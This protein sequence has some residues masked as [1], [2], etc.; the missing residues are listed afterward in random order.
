M[1]LRRIALLAVCMALT[2]PLF[3]TTIPPLL[4]Y[5]N[6]LARMA[7]L[8]AGGR[9]AD[10][11]QLYTIDWHIAPNLGLDM[12]VPLLAQLMP[13]PLA[14][15]IY[16]AL[17]L[18]LPVL[19]TV[20]LHDTVFG[21]RSWWPLASAIVVY[22]ATLL[23]G[24]LNFAIGIGLALLG[25]ACWIRLRHDRQRQILI[26]AA[27]AGAL[28]FIHAFAACFFLI[29][30]AGFECRAWQLKRNDRAAS[31][32]VTKLALT[33]LPTALLYL[34]T[35]LV[36]DTAASPR[37]LIAS[38]WSIAAPFDT[39]HKAIGAGASF[40]TYDTAS[41]LLLLIAVTAA[42]AALSLARKLAFAWPAAIAL[43]LMVVY[44]FVPN[45]IVGAGWVDTHLP[46]LAGFLL[47]AGITPRRLGRRET[48]VLGLA[49]ATLIVAR[50]G[51]ITLAWQ[52]QNADLANIAAVLTPVKADD[53]VLVLVASET[54]SGP[55][56]EPV[57]WRFFVDQPSFWHVAAPALLEHKAFYP[58]LFAEEAQQPLHV[59]PPYDK[60]A[61][62]RVSPPST[63][64]LWDRANWPTAQRQYPYL[65][66]WRHDFDYV[67]V[68]AAMRI[69]DR[70]GF[71]RDDLD[72]IMGTKMAAL[73]RVKSRSHE[74]APV[75]AQLP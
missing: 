66:T 40:F 67:L 27:I 41:D 29:M 16:L 70:K 45:A 26:G 24:F 25:T 21:K 56:S 19:G 6:H 13:L 35:W 2:V 53:R 42:I 36:A 49:F 33:A 44:L 57:R 74:T 7:V 39:L 75:T 4:D 34:Y 8:A 48:A 71:H 65:A 38:L 52:G 51:V 22:N 11:A 18:I 12:V 54:A 50:L 73:Y 60:L 9:D 23:A 58:Q 31:M 30:I 64:L 20:A 46:V 61:A 62:D 47:F 68:L 10:L 15:K 28:F 55:A 63:T 14:G 17:A 37:A 5:P 32:H 3:V 69:D 43:A 1:L 72:Y 59:R